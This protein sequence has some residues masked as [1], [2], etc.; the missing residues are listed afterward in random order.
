M[1]VRLHLPP[2]FSLLPLGRTSLA[3]SFAS[4][5]LIPSCVS[6]VLSMCRGIFTRLRVLYAS[7]SLLCARAS[8]YS[9][10]SSSAR[11]YAFSARVVFSMHLRSFFLRAPHLV[12]VHL[13]S[14]ALMRSWNIFYADRVKVRSS[15]TPQARSAGKNIAVSLRAF[16]FSMHLRLLFMRACHLIRGLL[17]SVALMHSRYM[18]Y[19]DRAEQR[20]GYTPYWLRCRSFRFSRPLSS[21]PCCHHHLPNSHFSS[22]TLLAPFC[23]FSGHP[24]S[25]K[26]AHPSQAACRCPPSS[27]RSRRRRSRLRWSLSVVLT[28]R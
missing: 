28:S 20:S 25:S 5:F 16:V 3:G 15:Y 6:F 1:C 12:R 27:P 17:R 14:L 18:L 24:A 13:S 21:L 10:S 8:S 7:R 23:T 26:S 9:C 22:P 11:A 19:A 2:V 4:P